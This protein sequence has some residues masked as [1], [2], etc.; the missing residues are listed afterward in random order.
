MSLPVKREK[1]E[2]EKCKLT[3]QKSRQPLTHRKLKR[4]SSKDFSKSSRRSKRKL[5]QGGDI[6][7]AGRSW[8]KIEII[9]LRKLKRGKLKLTKLSTIICRRKLRR[10][11]QK[12]RRPIKKTKLNSSRPEELKS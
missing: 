2:T 6:S 4:N 7:S 5:I 10:L 1:E 8:L 9:K 3:K 12:E 11:N